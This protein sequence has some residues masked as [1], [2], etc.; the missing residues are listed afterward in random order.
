MTDWTSKENVS[1]IA[2]W[3][4]IAILPILI[5]MGI[6]IDQA[7]LTAVVSTI[8][9]IGIAIYSSYNPNKIDGLG[10]GEPA[11]PVDELNGYGVDGEDDGC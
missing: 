1:T 8:I 3:V 4:G 10:N 2:T 9:V 5:K 6:D 7:T 11:I